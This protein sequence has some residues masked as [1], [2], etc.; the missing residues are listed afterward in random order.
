MQV[1]KIPI[2]ALEALLNTVSL[3]G[4]DHEEFKL[5][6]ITLA[7]YRGMFP[8]RKETMPKE[9]KSVMAQLQIMRSTLSPESKSYKTLSAEFVHLAYIG[10]IDR[11]IQTL[12][13]R[14][15]VD[16]EMEKV[17]RDP[18]SGKNDKGFF[19]NCLRAHKYEMC[20]TWEEREYIF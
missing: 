4:L 20:K 13:P 1:K 15:V 9:Q 3:F 8:D 10:A 7:S 16:F 2:N 18:K 14:T 11:A 17:L 5:E 12:D 19:R 6:L